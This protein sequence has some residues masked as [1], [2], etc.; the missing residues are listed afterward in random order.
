MAPTP[1]PHRFAPTAAWPGVAAAVLV[2]LAAAACTR[3]PVPTALVER[4]LA[5]RIQ[6]SV[7]FEGEAT[8]CLCPRPTLFA[9]AIE[10]GAPDWSG[11]PRFARL[12]D[13]EASVRP[14]SLLR[15]PPQIAS[16]RIGQ[17]EVVL[18]RAAD[19]RA[20]WQLPPKPGAPADAPAS[21][22][23]IERLEALDLTW[24]WI[25]AAH[26]TD[27]R[28]TLVIVDGLGLT[29]PD[30][31]ATEPR[32]D[33][34][35]RGTVRALPSVLSAHGGSMRRG[36]AGAYPIAVRGR[37][38]EGRIDFDGS[39]DT[40]ASLGGLRGEVALSGPA[41]A[42][43]GELVG[44]V[45]PRTPPFRLEGRIARVDERWTLAISKTRIGES[46]LRGDVEFVAASDSA[47]ARLQGRLDS[48]RMR[49]GDLGRS[50]GFGE[51]QGRRGRVLPNARLDLPSLGNMDAR[52]MIGIARLELGAGIAPVTD[53]A[54]ALRLEKGVLTI[55][56][57]AAGVA[58]GRIAGALQIDATGRPGRVKADLTM[59]EVA[60]ERWLPRLRGEPPIAARLN[61]ELAVE[62]RGDSIAEVLAH[63]DGRARFALGP[64]RASR[65]L[66]ELAGLD[67]AESLAA[68]VG[69]DRAIRLDCGL[70]ELAIE[71]GVVRPRVMFVDTRDTLL[72]AQGDLNLA[73][74]RISMRLRAA[75]RDAS[76]LTLRAPIDIAGTFADPSVSIDRT[77]VAGTVIASLVL[78]TLV[79]PIAA[80]LPLLDFG[81]GDP[82]SPCSTRYRDATAPRPAATTSPP[83]AARGPRQ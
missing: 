53:L 80:L 27:L 26:S 65:L 61:A 29:G 76:P 79:T 22:P 63:A 68:L 49:I 55:G 8:F 32:L 18:E 34:A 44:A 38:G 75:P 31:A 28:G 56:E 50:V 21:V 6:R 48:T 14:L 3:W 39:V 57:L 16:L 66:L 13:V 36:A 11:Q 40:L 17:G 1:A 4:L 23:V 82:P 71:R 52:L 51:P 72:T 7:R 74:E 64:G 83:G 43:L 47:P 9:D 69:G 45:L 62:G 37:V 60:L 33:L 10:V 73:D 67:I 2:T 77:R 70:A 54:A 42:A 46:D 58:G 15:D 41:L 5:E 12:R 20:S 19:G 59:R 35:A 81:E 24:R 25:D 30:A 78:G